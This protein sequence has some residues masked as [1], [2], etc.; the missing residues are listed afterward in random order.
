MPIDKIS[1]ANQMICFSSSVPVL[2]IFFC[3]FRSCR[4]LLKITI[5]WGSS[6]LSGRPKE[7]GSLRSLFTVGISQVILDSFP[8]LFV[9][10]F[11][12]MHRIWYCFCHWL[13]SSTNKSLSGVLPDFVVSLLIRIDPPATLRQ[14][15]LS[16]HHRSHLGRHL[17]FPTRQKT[18]VR[19]AVV[20]V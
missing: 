6:D 15:F 14:H 10:A 11:Q 19:E 1:F 9:W 7:L 16:E 12:W 2:L 8:V 13:C 18:C 3:R 5:F 20:T 4:F 17:S